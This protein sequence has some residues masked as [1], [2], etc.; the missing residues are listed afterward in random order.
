MPAI[1]TAYTNQW[2]LFNDLFQGKLGKPA[3]KMSPFWI[4]ITVLHDY[5][6]NKVC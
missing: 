6:E 1:L 5:I 4:L 2:H 3:P